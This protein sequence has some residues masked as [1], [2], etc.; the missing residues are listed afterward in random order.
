VPGQQVTTRGALAGRLGLALASFVATIGLLEIVL[1]LVAPMVYS[2]DLH[3]VPDGHVKARLD[4]GQSAVNEH[5]HRVQLN[6][7]GFRGAEPTP[8]PAPGTLRVIALGGSSTFCY[9]VS[10]DAHT[11]PARLE[12]RLAQELG[13]PVEVINLGL[14][15]YDAANSKVNYL[16]TGRALHPHVV[17]VY[18]TWNDMKLIRSVD[19]S[20]MLPRDALSGR[21]GAST[22]VSPLARFL[23]D[24][25]VS[26]RVRRAYLALRDG[27]WENYYGSLEGRG[28]DADA[29][30]G[31]RGWRWFRQNFVDVVRFAHGDGVLPV[32][33]SEATLAHPEALRDTARRA[34]IRNE[35][36]D[37]TLP[38]LVETWPETVRVLRDVAEREGAV[39]VD[40]YA[41]VPGDPDHL[42][43]H[44]HLTDRGADRL[45]EAVA[46]TLV[47]DERFRA[48]VAQV[49][50]S[51]A[52]AP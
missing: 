9:E 8:E 5:G 44:V 16:F 17:L 26:Q 19:A 33:I 20:A 41:A 50:A 32:V 28:R 31:D 2:T 36:L 34:T 27:A 30:I 40:G 51:G 42:R 39:F 11:W 38:R 13:V 12:A 1:R 23:W 49:R 48:V 52:A 3:W 37:M 4:A 22:N 43:D 45:A 25:Q 24:T 46:T 15:G 7:L 10:D 35:L 47:K 6:S 18:H 29:P 21:S 14:P